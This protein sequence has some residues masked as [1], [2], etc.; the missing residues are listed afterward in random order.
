MRLFILKIEGVGMRNVGKNTAPVRVP[1]KHIA[2]FKPLSPNAP[3]VLMRFP[4]AVGL[5]PYTR[6][7]G[8]ERPYRGVRFVAAPI[9]S[10]AMASSAFKLGNSSR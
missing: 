7:P 4:G 3:T 5:A 1:S 2:V 9:S 8:S 10:R 6:S